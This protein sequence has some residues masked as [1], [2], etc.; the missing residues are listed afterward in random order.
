MILTLKKIDK[1]EKAKKII[2]N[3]DMSE[4]NKI[5]LLKEIFNPIKD[6]PDR[7]LVQSVVGCEECSHSD[8]EN[9]CALDECC[10]LEGSN[11]WEIRGLYK[12]DDDDDDEDF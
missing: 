9:G 4:F 1:L 8:F 2:F 12:N 6:M 11:N 7:E 3:D 5:K 10:Y